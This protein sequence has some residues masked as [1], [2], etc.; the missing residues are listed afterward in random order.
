MNNP[1]HIIVGTAGHVDHGKTLLTAALTGIDTDRLPEEKKRGMTIVPGF[2]SLNLQSGRRLGLID[3]PGHEKFVKNML[4][5]VAG[6]DMVMLV[7]AADEGVMP[8]TVEHLNILHL[9]GIDKGVV[10]ITKIDMVDEEWLA[11]I[12]EQVQELI[13]ST[14]LKN[15][16]IV[17]V[18]AYKGQNIDTLLNVLDEVAA[19]LEEKPCSGYCRLPIDRVFSKKGFGTV[20]TGTLWNGRISIGQ[21][22][23]LMPKE[24]EVRVRG[25]QV[26]G[27]PVEEA[28]A[29]QRTAINLAGTEIDKVVCGSWLAEPGL[30]RETL[31]IDVN[32]NLLA[33]AKA[34]PQR[35][36]VRIHHGTAEV[37]GRINLLDRDKLMPGESHTAQLILEAPLSPLRGDRLIIRAYSPMLTIGGAIVLDPSPP[38]HKRFDQAVLNQLS[39]KQGKDTGE[40]ILDLICKSKKPLTMAEIANL[41]QLML[42]EAEPYIEKYR[43][44]GSLIALKIDNEAQYISLEQKNNLLSL[45]LIQL[46]DYHQKY[47]LRRGMPVAE[48]RQRI[49]PAYHVKQLAVLLEKWREEAFLSVN[50]AVVSLADFLYRPNSK[51]EKVLEKI[52]EYYETAKF[53]PLKWNDLMKEFSIPSAEAG[54]YQL[55]LLENAKLIKAGELFYA[56]GAIKEAA[57]ILRKKFQ[58]RSFTIGEA[59]DILNISRKYT[60][61]ILDYLDMR[62]I[63][64]REEDTRRFLA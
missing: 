23:Q 44:N 55:W 19:S 33:S 7:I 28:L 45:T 30:L 53:T 3:V 6:I 63:T 41:A 39:A 51:Q 9:L 17:A 49:F 18:S 43:E 38:K 24:C 11:M 21:K 37:L 31:R 32:L 25:L 22:L 5:G 12:H 59:R 50:G 34:L 40:A 60:Q 36:R 54:E 26:H 58:A 15:A 47:P 1:K 20:V 13:A 57:D 61:Y 14:S 8:Q 48:L 16:P 2:V 64:V 35:A 29:G 10:V 62:K 4:A 52:I 42:S 46:R 27:K 56:T